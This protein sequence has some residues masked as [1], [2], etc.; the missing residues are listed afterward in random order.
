VK[1]GRMKLSCPVHAIAVA[2]LAAL[3]PHAS[4]EQ[5]SQ[6]ALLIFEG[7][8]TE[9]FSGVPIAGAE[10][11]HGF[12]A[13]AVT[14]SDGRYRIETRYGGP[15]LTLSAVSPGFLPETREQQLTCE[16]V[17]PRGEIP[18]CQVEFDFEMRR[19]EL[20]GSDSP[21]CT[22]R[23]TVLRRSDRLPV[24]GARIRVDGTAMSAVTGPDG[25]YLIPGVPAGLHRVTARSSSNFGLSRL[26]VVRCASPRD[27]PTLPLQLSPTWIP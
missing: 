5:S 11:D 9:E 20:K 27:G 12:P 25:A 15:F 16:F 21:V 17:A 6:R 4:A 26:A 13:T 10:V 19:F 24:Q 18:T 1:G 2:L 22:I 23:G 14:D 7:R 8:V 3:A